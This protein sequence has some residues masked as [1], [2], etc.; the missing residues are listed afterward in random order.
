[1]KREGGEGRCF[2][3]VLRVALHDASGMGEGRREGWWWRGEG[4]VGRRRQGVL[5][6]TAGR[7][8]SG[9]AGADCPGCAPA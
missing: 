9:R 4:E 2:S 1:M 5:T 7:D 8:T 3:P 6:C